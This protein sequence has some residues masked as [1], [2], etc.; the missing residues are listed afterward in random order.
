[1]IMYLNINNVC[2]HDIFK[3]IAL[4]YFLFTRV[5]LMNINFIFFKELIK[6]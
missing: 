6:N 2:L 5:L 4:L 1:M 3:Y